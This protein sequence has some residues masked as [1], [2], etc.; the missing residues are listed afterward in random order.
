MALKIKRAKSASFCHK[1]NIRSHHMFDFLSY[2]R[3]YDGFVKYLKHHINPQNPHKLPSF[4]FTSCFLARL[5][6]T[7]AFLPFLSMCLLLL[8]YCEIAF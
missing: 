3:V 2:K 8:L 6:L 1:I 4:D 5:T 7:A